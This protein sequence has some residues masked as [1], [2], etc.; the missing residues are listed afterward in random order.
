MSL[1][2]PG[3]LIPVLSRAQIPLNSYDSSLTTVLYMGL[4]TVTLL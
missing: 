1:P 4:S 3:L 2:V